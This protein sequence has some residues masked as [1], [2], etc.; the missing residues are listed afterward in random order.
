MVRKID[1]KEAFRKQQ[2]HVNG[3]V[4][5]CQSS[6]LLKSGCFPCISSPVSILKIKFELKFEMKKR[7][8]GFFFIIFLSERYWK[9]QCMC[10][11][12]VQR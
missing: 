7:G 8:E 4:F 11:S 9:C 5:L 3:K 12:D 10:I 6:L 1:A 2:G